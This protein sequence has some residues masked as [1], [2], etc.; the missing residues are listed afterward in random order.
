MG[1]RQARET[2]LQVMFQVD[3]GRADLEQALQNT[4]REFVVGAEDADFARELVA[5][6]LKN[7][8]EL[9]QVITNLSKEWQLNRMANVDRNVMRLALY[10]I[11]YRPDI[12]NSVSV[13]EAVEL[14][15][16]FGGAESGKFVNGI[17]GKVVADPA[18]FH[19]PASS[20]Q[21]QG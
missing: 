4:V 11:F 14:A 1:R 21:S 2:A 5:G 15:K 18:Q 7:L 6:A 13:N 20:G 17:L 10:E 16:I 8:P 3:V 19:Q 9:D 12:P